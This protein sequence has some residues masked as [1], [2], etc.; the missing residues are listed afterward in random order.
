VASIHISSPNCLPNVHFT[1]FHHLLER[2]CQ[3]LT[4]VT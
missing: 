4:P 1:V 2:L 3:K